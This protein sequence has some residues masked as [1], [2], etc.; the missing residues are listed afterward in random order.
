MIDTFITTFKLRNAY[1]V[2]T[3][4]YGLRNLP[5][6]KRVLK[7]SLYGNKGIKIFVD[8]LS[9]LG[10]V[11]S[12]FLGKAF[13]LGLMILLPLTFIKSATPESFAH[14][15]LFLTLAGGLMNTGLFNPSK[16]KYYAI[17]LM[18]MDSREYTLVSY[19]Y[20]MVKLLVGFLPFTLLFS[21]IAD[22]S[23]LVGLAMPFL[24]VAIK[25]I[26]A[27]L[28]LLAFK[29]TQVVKNENLPTPILWG[30]MT[31]LTAIAYVPVALGFS[32]SFVIFLSFTA[33][34]IILSIPAFRYIYL[35]DEFRRIYKGLLVVDNFVSTD[36]AS[37]A[38]VSKASY[39]KK[40]SY[41]ATSDKEGY[42]YFNELFM[43]RYQKILLKSAIRTTVI[44]SILIIAAII[45]I[46]IFPEAKS[47]VNGVILSYL[48]YFLFV[49]YMINKGKG[50]THIM[51]L[52]CDHSMLSYRFY[53][54]PKAIL[55]LFK[56][57]LKYIIGINLPPAVVI[58]LGLAVLLWIT[59]GT[60]N[61]IN[62]LLLLVSILAMSVFFSVH[63]IVMYYLLQP[64]NPQLQMK[65]IAFTIVDY[66]T[67]IICYMAIGQ[68]A[69]TLIFGTAISAFCIFYV[70][71]AL[72]LAYR[73]A[74]KTF[75]LRN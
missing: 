35:F 60:S 24:V 18:R 62:Y 66:V 55:L 48:P 13:Y 7:T 43:K 16:D 25:G 37:I 30:V 69:P 39:E 42:K 58:G 17:F 20:F 32:L 68:Q 19:L 54:Q 64:Y 65:N 22:V 33:L 41:E 28:D 56:E 47:D 49:M 50:I 59:G 52:N 5:G 31:I 6:F 61:P 8:I 46:M 36:K 45:V 72:I 29:R 23:L 11:A 34:A 70:V 14:V 53:R 38:K 9:I 71:L 74:P 10:E 63:N 3:I 75:R 21:V 40:L 12:I 44:I 27:A 26:V 1:R 73:L 57:R 15:F 67:Y 4:I 51:F 2:N